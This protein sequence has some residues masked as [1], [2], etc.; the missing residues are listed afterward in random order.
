MNQSE[1]LH[2]VYVHIPFCAKRC[3]YCAFA[4]F[5]DRHHLQGEYVQALRK[6]IQSLVVAGMPLSLIQLLPCRRKERG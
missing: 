1:G 2:G 5:T 4:T 3:D 6:H